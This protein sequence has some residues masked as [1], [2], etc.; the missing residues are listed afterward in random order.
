M[1]EA[2][3]VFTRDAVITKA[4]ERFKLSSQ[5]YQSQRRREKDALEFQV[6]SKQW[7]EAVQA[8]RKAET[9]GGIALPARPMLSI[10]TLD[11]PIQLILN[12]ERN[13]HLGVQ[14]HPKDEHAT[15][16]T[17]EVM[18]GLYRQIEV[19]SRAALARSWGHE[20]AVK[21]GLGWY[22]VLTVPDTDSPEPNDQKIVIRR[23]LYQ[24][25]VFP[26]P[27]AQEPDWSDGEFLFIVQ[28]IPVSRYKKKYK[29]EGERLSGL[30]DQA[31]NDLAIECPLWVTGEGEGRAVLV[32][33][34]FDVEV[35]EDGK[36]TVTWRTINAVEELEKQVWLGQ[37]IPVVPCV[38]RELIPF[39][40]ERR[41]VGIIE[42]NMDS[43]RLVNYSA[44]G[45]VETLS[46]EPRAPFDVDPE[47]IKGYEAFYQ[48]SNVRNFPY[49]PRHKVVRGQLMPPLARVQADTGKLQ[50]SMMMLEHAKDFV[51]IGTGAYEPTL[52]KESSSGSSARKEMAL[53]QQHE[54]SSSNWLDNLANI[55]INYESR[56]VTDLMPKI[57]DREERIVRILD[58]EDK[59]QTVMLNAPF[60]MNEK[61]K[62]PMGTKSMLPGQMPPQAGQVKRYDLGKGKYGW[63]VS[64]GK[65]YK[66][67]IDQ[68]ADELGQLFQA[69][70][71]LFSLLGDIYLRFRDFPGHKEA[72]DRIQKMLPPQLQGQDGQQPTPEQL[73]GQLQKAT[74]MLQAI[75]KELNAKNQYIETKTQEFERDV[76][77]KKAELQAKKDLQ[78]MINAAN[79]RIA[80][81]NA[82]VKGYTVE[83]QHAAAHEAQALDIDA[84]AFEGSLERENAALE[85]NRQRE[86]EA[87]MGQQGVEG[88]IA[89]NAAKPQ[90]SNGAGA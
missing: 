43:A 66:S 63:T 88:Q 52:G 72:A 77:L 44:S 22:R 8:T 50:M 2:E 59:A 81:I 54:E 82:A 76:E 45:A 26:D 83:A 32:A 74:Q 70:P 68:G 34:Y 33:E 11:Q 10:P 12:Q 7:P 13:A 4:L 27:F 87:A 48:Q 84:R 47:E 67:R 25:S 41:W 15:D 28:W 16:E 56:V 35:A 20:R 21:A 49:M 46:L 19:D 6:P 75:T 17:A 62:R 42:P 57:Y 79:I 61:T 69:E 18:Q 38:G 78:E 24:E 37:W 40:Q 5:T 51:H 71:Q 23:I 90:P 3:P 80:E 30:D 85:A 86:H 53:V 64:V 14:I 36:R 60:V 9:I 55:S 1:S 31:L 39:D 73:Q 58:L 29:K 65:A 89:V